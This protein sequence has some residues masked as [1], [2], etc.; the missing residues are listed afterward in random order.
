MKKINISFLRKKKFLLKFTKDSL[1][2]NNLLQTGEILLLKFVSL[3][4]DT[5]YKYKLYGVCIGKK[6]NLIMTSSYIN[7]ILFGNRINFLFYIYSPFVFGVKTFLQKN[8]FFKRSKAFN[9]KPKMRIYQEL[10]KEF[11]PSLIF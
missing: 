11:D 8:H 6:N 10:L 4:R 1:V 3:D 2:F 5:L 9:F 7:T